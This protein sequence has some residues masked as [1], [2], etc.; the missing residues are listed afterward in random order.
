MIMATV[1]TAEV[2]QTA[3]SPTETARRVWSTPEA[4]D[5][6]TSMEVTAYAARR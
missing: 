6:D 3:P 2:P 5:F 4:D 1:Q